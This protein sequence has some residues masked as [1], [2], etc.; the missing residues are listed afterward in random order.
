MILHDPDPLVRIID[1]SDRERRGIKRRVS[2]RKG[3]TPDA[4]TPSGRA[5]TAEAPNS[6]ERPATNS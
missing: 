3:T 4:T 2:R 6:R 5:V 1:Q